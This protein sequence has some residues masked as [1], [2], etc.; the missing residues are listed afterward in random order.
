MIILFII[1]EEG[2]GID[3]EMICD[4]QKSVRYLISNRK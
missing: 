3:G 1:F 2:Q 4:S